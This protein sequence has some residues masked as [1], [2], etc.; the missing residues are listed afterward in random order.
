MT[1]LRDPLQHEKEI[2]RRTKAENQT[3]VKLCERSLGHLSDGFNLIESPFKS[4]ELNRTILLLAT[5]GYDSLRWSF[6]LLLKGYYGQ[7][8]ALARMAWESWLHGAYVL[9]YPKRLEEWREFKTRPRPFDMRMLVAKAVA[10]GGPMTENQIRR[11]LSNLYSGYSEYSHPTDIA[12]RVLVAK[13]GEEWSLRLGGE[14]DQTLYLQ[15]VEMFCHASEALFALLYV[16]Q[17]DEKD[18]QTQGDALRDEFFAWRDETRER[19]KSQ[20]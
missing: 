17:P 8:I 18:Y 3:E 6:E 11:G 5:L 19:L 20:S 16:L 9:L 2:A 7:S 12:L 4:E 14:Y 15:S 10:K 13:R 1:E